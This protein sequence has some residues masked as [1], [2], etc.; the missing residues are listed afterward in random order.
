MRGSRRQGSRGRAP[1]RAGRRAR[2][3]LG[4]R[5]A[6]RRAREAE[7][8]ALCSSWLETLTPSL[9]VGSERSRSL[10]VAEHSVVLGVGSA[11][12]VDTP[13]RPGERGAHLVDLAAV[14]DQLEDAIAGSDP[15]QAKAPLRLLIAAAGA[16]A[17]APGPGPAT[18]SGVHSLLCRSG[19]GPGLRHPATHVVMNVTDGTSAS[20]SSKRRERRAPCGLALGLHRDIKRICLIH[21]ARSW[22][23]LLPAPGGLAKQFELEGRDVVGV[24]VIVR[25]AP[26]ET[27]H[28]ARARPSLPP[29]RRRARDGRPDGAQEASHQSSGAASRHDPGRAAQTT[30]SARSWAR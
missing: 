4:L 11:A 15:K 24:T 6:L 22:R 21:T 2:A 20:V 1:R 19:V 30:R 25:L 12:I 28:P 5:H 27:A 7:R 23:S 9:S 17:T 16:S 18:P 8:K 3:P 14:A 10:S 26:L 29:E 13:E